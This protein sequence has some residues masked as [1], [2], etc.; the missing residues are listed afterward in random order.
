MAIAANSYTLSNNDHYPLAYYTQRKNEIRYYYSW[1]FTTYKDWSTTPA[2][3]VVEPGL[4]WQGDTIK[5]INQCPSFKGAHNWFA[6]PYTGYNYNTSYIGINEIAFPVNSAK[7]TDVKRPSETALF[8]DGQYSAGVNKYM[9]APFSNPRDASFSDPG[10]VAGTQGY[11]HI[12][13]T[14]IAFCDGHIESWKN[15]F[16]NMDSI[17]QEQLDR[18][19]ETHN[20]KIGFLSEDNGIYDLN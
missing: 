18:Y 19:N 17:G 3:E 4:L 1:D 11:R 13:K 14:N 5:K 20:V 15:L 6:D 8:G 9:R 10:R 16:T 12:G 2:K 7:T